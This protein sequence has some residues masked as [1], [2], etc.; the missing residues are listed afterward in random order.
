VKDNKRRLKDGGLLVGRDTPDRSA[1][2]LP[3][4]APDWSPT[5]W[6]EEFT[7]DEALL[8]PGPRSNSIG[9]LGVSARECGSGI[10]L[11]ALSA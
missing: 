10:G 8:A 6:P 3:R 4:T 9:Q 2:P 1:G 5:E 7:R 11:G